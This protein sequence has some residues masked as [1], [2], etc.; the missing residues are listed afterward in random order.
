[1]APLSVN[2]CTSPV[3]AVAPSV[4]PSQSAT[5]R[6]KRADDSMTPVSDTAPLVV[7]SS[8]SACNMVPKASAMVVPLVLAT[9][10]RIVML[11]A[12]V[13]ISA[14]CRLTPRA[15]SVA[16][17]FFWDRPWPCTWPPAVWMLVAVRLSPQP[18]PL[19][20][21]PMAEPLPTVSAAAPANG[22]QLLLPLPPPIHRPPPLV[23]IRVCVAPVAPSWMAPPPLPSWSAHNT[24]FSLRVL[25]LLLVASMSAPALTMMFRLAFSVSVASA[26]IAPVTMSVATVMSPWLAPAPLVSSTT[27]LPLFSAVTMELACTLPAVP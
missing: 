16:L 10:P 19:A 17:L 23:L 24:R 26:A 9:S 14:P 15:V 1:M 5:P 18:V 7:C 4:E 12:P 22:V 11:P 8:V 20:S 2:T 27:L 6:L 21:V 13:M 3:A 25:L